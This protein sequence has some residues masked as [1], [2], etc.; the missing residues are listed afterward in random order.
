[1]K[2]EKVRDRERDRQKRIE[3]VLIKWCSIRDHRKQ[4]RA[5]TRESEGKSES[6]LS[7][8]PFLPSQQQMEIESEQKSTRVKSRRPQPKKNDEKQSRMKQR[9]EQPKNRW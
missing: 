6:L 7:I 5:H 1:V 4:E 9:K 2:H 3:D 8:V